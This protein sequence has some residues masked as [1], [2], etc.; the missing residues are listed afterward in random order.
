MIYLLDTNIFLRVLVPEDEQDLQDCK[1]LLE[2]VK[3][4]Q[5]EAVTPGVVLA[6]ISWVMGSYYRQ[7]RSEISEKM[8]GIVKLGGLR[9]V[10]DYNWVSSIELYGKT[11]VKFLDAVLAAMPKVAVGEW[12][13]VSLDSDFK[14]LPVKW[15]RPGEVL[16]RG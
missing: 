7:S 15:L 4:L 14:K 6:E 10:D 13:I 9:I 1:R 12:T 16:G 11:K 5:I 8:S 3:K 2:D